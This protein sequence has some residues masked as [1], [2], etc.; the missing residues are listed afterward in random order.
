MPKYP[1]YYIRPDGLH[2]TILRING[3]RKAFRG[4]TDKEVWEKVKAFDR[5][6]L[7]AE[8]DAE[9][10][11]S[12]IAEQWWDEAEPK[13]EP[14]SVK[15]YKPALRRAVDEFGARQ[16]G[17]IT[18]KEIDAFIRDF[19]A[20]R[21]RKTVAMQLQVIR[22]ILRWA[23]LQGKTNYNPAQAVRVPRNLPQARRE[24]PDKDQIAKI[25][26]SANLPF[27]LF[28]ALIYY[29]GCRRG[30]AQALTG[31]D[32]DRKAMRVH[33][34]RSVYYDH[35]AKI[36][37]PKTAAGVPAPARL[38]CASAEKTAARVSICRAGRL[39]ADRRRFPQALQGVLRRQRRDGLSASDPAWLRNRTV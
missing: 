8:I 6:Q 27:G 26:T 39:A 31:S 14:N 15:N 18:A 30:E 4:K 24:A 34:R 12:R 5:A 21:A 32:I 7:Q 9:T 19:A 1:S 33:I 13:L 22:Q 10:T 38:G 23:E 11:F 2:E 20:A 36:K 3:K 17:S 35:G 29:T 37:E 28:P 16:V 25:K